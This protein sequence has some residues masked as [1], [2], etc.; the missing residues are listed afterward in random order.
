MLE[1]LLEKEGLL[2]NYLSI[3]LPFV[4]IVCSIEL[5]GIGFDS[6]EAVS[7]RKNLQT[8]LDKITELA[9]KAAG[10]KFSISSPT[11]CAKVQF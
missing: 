1:K 3:E 10:R 7:L 8:E 9:H 2:E 6:T 5:R 11:D 4:R